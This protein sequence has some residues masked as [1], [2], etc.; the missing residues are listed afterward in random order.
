[1]QEEFHPRLERLG[2]HHLI[3]TRLSEEERKVLIQ[4][5]LYLSNLTDN[6]PHL[7]FSADTGTGE[8]GASWLSGPRNG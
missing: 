2:C 8:S 4:L 6:W 3:R 5:S 7:G 1:M